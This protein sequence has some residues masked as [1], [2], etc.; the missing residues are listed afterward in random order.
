[1]GR[2]KTKTPRWTRFERCDDASYRA[3]LARYGDALARRPELTVW[4]NSRYQVA[5]TIHDDFPIGVPI[6]HLSIKR[7]DRKP[8]HDWRDLQRIKNELCGEEREAVE[9]YPAETRLVDEA[10]QFHLWVFPEGMMAP[11]GYFGDRVVHAPERA[12][13]SSSDGSKQRPFEEDYPG[14]VKPYLPPGQ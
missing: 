12:D 2:N 9:L 7:L 5:V 3:H 4:R 13:G 11:F 8:I 14:E 1:M 6:I 10:N